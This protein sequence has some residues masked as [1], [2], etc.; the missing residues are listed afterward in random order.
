VI[1][2]YVGLKMLAVGK[3]LEL[4]PPTWLSLVVI[5]VVLTLAITL[6]L[7]ADTKDADADDSVEH[8]IA[9]DRERHGSNGG[10]G[11]SKD[12]GE[13]DEELEGDPR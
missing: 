4:H 1:L 3:P 11:G 5:A 13:P 10:P 9:V 6:S 2:A 8:E 7:R 12:A